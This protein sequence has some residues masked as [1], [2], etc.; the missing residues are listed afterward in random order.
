MR[1]TG[2]AFA[3]C[4]ILTAGLAIAALA[5]VPKEN[6]YRMAGRFLV[7]EASLTQPDLILVLGGDFFGA[8]VVHAARLGTEGV[9]PRVLI[10]GPPYHQQFESDLAIE[11]LNRKHGYPRSLFIGFQHR[12]RNT[13]EEAVT[14]RPELER[15]RVK[16]VLLVTSNY[17]SRRALAIFRAMV[18]G[19]EFGMAPAD[20][21]QFHPERWWLAAGERRLVEREFTS[22]AWNLTVG[23]ALAEFGLAR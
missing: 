18:P 10:S 1:R 19:I 7:A 14:L 13:L 4:A 2:R 9:A 21:P 6:L 15:L 23:R 12:A 17:H 11:Y 22:L 3:G 20:D 16:K 5:A 8:R